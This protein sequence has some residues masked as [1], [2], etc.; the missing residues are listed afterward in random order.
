MKN[1]SVS[2]LMFMD[3][4]RF[5]NLLKIRDSMS[6]SLS[7][8]IVSDFETASLDNIVDFDQILNRFLYV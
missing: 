3:N 2:K 7:K 5:L 1:I 8:K 6:H 4:K